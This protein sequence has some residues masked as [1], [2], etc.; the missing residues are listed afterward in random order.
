[1][2]VRGLSRMFVGLDL[3]GVCQEGAENE[4]ARLLQSSGMLG[5]LV[6]ILYQYGATR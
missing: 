1:M 3:D 5:G 2:S 4:K 6:L